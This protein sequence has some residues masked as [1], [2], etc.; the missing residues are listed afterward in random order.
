MR[1]ELLFIPKGIDIGAVAKQCRAPYSGPKPKRV[2]TLYHFSDPSI[3][4][5]LP[6]QPQHNV[7]AFMEDYVHDWVMTPGVFHYKSRVCEGGVWVLL[8]LDD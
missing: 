4:P 6:Y 5:G 1:Q 3:P 8:E 2:W 7:N